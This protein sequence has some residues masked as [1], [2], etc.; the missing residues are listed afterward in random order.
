[1]NPGVLAP[2]HEIK[3]LCVGMLSSLVDMR[4]RLEVVRTSH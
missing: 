4:R 3:A 1:M 2:I